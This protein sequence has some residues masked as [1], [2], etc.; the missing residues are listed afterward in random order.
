MGKRYEL[1]VTPEQAQ[2]ALDWISETSDMVPFNSDLDV[3]LDA[4]GALLSD[5][6]SKRVP[7]PTFKPCEE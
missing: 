1:P 2:L 5:I 6:V 4:L 3:A 7:L